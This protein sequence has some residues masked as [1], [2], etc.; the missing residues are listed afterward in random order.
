MKKVLLVDDSALMRSIVSGIIEK[1]GRFTIKDI[2]KNGVEAL[3]F[4]EKNYYDAVIS[5][6]IMPHM[7]GVEMLREIGKRGLS[8]KVLMLSTETSEGAK[9]TLDCLE[10]GAVDFVH[11][12]G[13][14]SMRG[15]DFKQELLSKLVVVSESRSPVYGT[16]R[17]LGAVKTAATRTTAI[18]TGA[19]PTKLV[20]IASS[21]GG[22]RAL[23]SVVTALPADLDAPVV[24]VQHMPTGFTKAL[25]ERL[26]AVC[27]IN[28][29]E[30]EEGDALVNGQVY[31]SKGGAHFN[32]RYSAGKYTVYYSDEPAREGVKPCA[33]YL[34][35]SLARCPL[36]RICC[37]VLTG[38]GADG[39]EGIKNLKRSGKKIFVIGQ[40]EKT[41]TVYGMPRA[42]ARA[43]LTDKVVELDRVAAEIISSL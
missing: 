43:G 25:A 33:N 23:Q 32:V 40:D 27:K 4:L 19:K 18:V 37:V 22:P 14:V 1:D 13:P 3:G 36:E 9:V 31:I 11:K 42:V 41:S 8:P 38:M 2:A 24:I 35:E 21:T 6:V 26:D 34:F 7:S 30:A 15:E 10:L 16:L 39:T 5:D 17:L 28:V 20:A 29:K 12:P